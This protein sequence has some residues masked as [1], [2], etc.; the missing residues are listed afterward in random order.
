SAADGRGASDSALTSSPTIAAERLISPRI[1]E[2][3][4]RGNA[5]EARRLDHQRLQPGS[6]RHERGIVGQH[7]AGVQHVVD[8]N[9]QQRARGPVTAVESS[10]SCART[11]QL[12]VA[13]RPTLTPADIVSGP[14]RASIVA[15]KPSKAC[16]HLPKCEAALTTL[17]TSP[18]LSGTTS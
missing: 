4:L 14:G 1:S 18:A 9:R 6:L 8:V 16:V 11:S 2:L 17:V 15:S 12:S 3:D 5:H 13:V 7:R 10:G